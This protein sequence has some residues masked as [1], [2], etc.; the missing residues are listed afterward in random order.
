MWV[1]GGAGEVRGRRSHEG[2]EARR[3]LFWDRTLGLRIAD[4]GLRIDEARRLRPTGY[5]R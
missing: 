5:L 1:F 2:T 4:F 3:G